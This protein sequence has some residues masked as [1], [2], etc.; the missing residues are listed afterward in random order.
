MWDYVLIGILFIGML[1]VSIKGIEDKIYTPIG[2][3]LGVLLLVGVSLSVIYIIAEEYAGTKIFHYLLIAIGIYAI[4]SLVADKVDSRLKDRLDQ[5]ENKLDTIED[6][7]S[8][9]KEPFVR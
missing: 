2:N 9:R 3:L 6:A 1:I 5:L 8:P 7:L 4:A